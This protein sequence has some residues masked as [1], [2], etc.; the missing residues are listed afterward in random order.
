MFF[1]VM[2]SVCVECR[3]VLCRY[4]ECRFGET[5]GLD[6]SRFALTVSFGKTPKLERLEEVKVVTRLP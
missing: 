3:Y 2:L 1:I 5:F 4:A 6:L